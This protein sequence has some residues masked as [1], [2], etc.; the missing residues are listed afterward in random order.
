MNR[1]QFPLVFSQWLVDHWMQT[2]ADEMQYQLAAIPAMEFCCQAILLVF[3]QWDLRSEAQ[4]QHIDR[5]YDDMHKKVF[6]DPL[7]TL[8]DRVR[9]RLKWMI[10]MKQQLRLPATLER[11]QTDK[12]IACWPI[13]WIPQSHWIVFYDPNVKTPKLSHQLCRL[14]A[15]MDRPAMIYGCSPYAVTQA[16][17][18]RPD[19]YTTS[20]ISTEFIHADLLDIPVVMPMIK[21]DLFHLLTH[22]TRPYMRAW[23]TNRMQQQ[24]FVFPSWEGSD[25]SQLDLPFCEAAHDWYEPDADGNL[26]MKRSSYFRYYWH[27][28]TNTMMEE[29]DRHATIHVRALTPSITNSLL[30]PREATWSAMVPTVL[31]SST[32]T[33]AAEEDHDDW[34]EHAT[35]ADIELDPVI[36][37]PVDAPNALQTPPASP[38]PLVEE[39]PVVETV[40]RPNIFHQMMQV[41]LPPPPPVQVSGKGHYLQHGVHPS[42]MVEPP[43][44]EDALILQQAEMEVVQSPVLMTDPPVS[45]STTARP[46]KAVTFQEDD[47]DAETTMTAATTASGRKRKSS[48]SSKP[49][50]KKRIKGVVGLKD[51]GYLQIQDN[52]RAVVKSF[53]PVQF[54]AP[55][56]IYRVLMLNVVALD[57]VDWPKLFDRICSRCFHHES[58]RA[59]LAYKLITDFAMVRAMRLH[60]VEIISVCDFPWLTSLSEPNITDQEERFELGSTMVWV[61]PTEDGWKYALD[62]LADE[63]DVDLVDGCSPRW[64]SVPPSILAN[65]RKEDK[66]HLGFLNSWVMDG[67]QAKLS[68]YFSVMQEW[69]SR[70]GRFSLTCA[71]RTMFGVTKKPNESH[72]VKNLSEAKCKD[73]ELKKHLHAT[74]FHTK[75]DADVAVVNGRFANLYS[76]RLTSISKGREVKDINVWLP[77]NVA[78]ADEMY[79]MMVNSL[80]GKIVNPNT[81]Y[82]PLYSPHAIGTLLGAMYLKTHWKPVATANVPDAAWFNQMFQVVR[83]LVMSLTNSSLEDW[84]DSCVND[85]L[86]LMET[87]TAAVH[88]HTDK[89]NVLLLSTNDL[90][91]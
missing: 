76:C 15:E 14:F 32:L 3:N 20:H 86:A 17:G 47:S 61:P 89:G 60:G 10:R 68:W 29:F 72:F 82:Q 21:G 80:F 1:S 41:E 79:P 40:V 49:E 59:Y 66:E 77:A 33:A 91:A 56:I 63:L 16:P 84:M 39:S 52:L 35:F 24:P 57:P 22:V 42:L 74:L 58:V 36:Q 71:V 83:P 55:P 48:K 43:D 70:H 23:F 64:A 85:T 28:W 2:H 9:Q 45:S 73:K 25:A 30:R 12:I 65:L 62:A 26:V 75:T 7:V 38:R 53:D 46:S 50:T 27:G 88:T 18:Q 87:N 78:T 8:C 54:V 37:P 51:M 34:F 44:D 6:Y 4:L 5:M 11:F 81:P 67:N 19:R 13:D 69:T 31:P 90:I